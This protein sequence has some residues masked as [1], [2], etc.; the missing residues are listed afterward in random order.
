MNNN[1][2]TRPTALCLCHHTSTMYVISKCLVRSI[3]CHPL[4]Q[5][6]HR[7]HRHQHQLAQLVALLAGTC[8]RLALN[9][10]AL[11]RFLDR[12]WL[13]VMLQPGLAHHLRHR[14][15]LGLRRLRL[16]R[17][18]LRRHRP[19]LQQ[20]HLTLGFLRSSMRCKMLQMLLE[21]I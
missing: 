1:A 16:R 11:S 6:H 19:F 20:Q 13:G 12:T 21:S 2:I 4:Y 3:S 18:F 10:R 15:L 14:D 5:H 8:R 17:P 9:L 7:F